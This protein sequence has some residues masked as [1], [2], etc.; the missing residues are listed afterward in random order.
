MFEGDLN[1]LFIDNIHPFTDDGQNCL[2]QSL[3][4][5]LAALDDFLP[6]DANFFRLLSVLSESINFD[7]A[8]VSMALL[9]WLIVA[10]LFP[11]V[12]LCFL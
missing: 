5:A 6:F 1:S 10:S 7:F 3:E 11:S 2:F 9:K 4:T 12:Q 8:I